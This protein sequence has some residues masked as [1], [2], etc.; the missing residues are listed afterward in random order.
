MIQAY[1]NPNSDFYGFFPR[2]FRA[3]YTICLGAFPPLHQL[4]DVIFR[5]FLGGSGLQSAAAVSYAV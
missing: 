1:R 4:E 3:I 2:N 5:P